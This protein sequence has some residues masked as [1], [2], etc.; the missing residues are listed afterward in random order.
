[1]L[2]LTVFTHHHDDETA[3]DEECSAC[4]FSEHHTAVVPAIADLVYLQPDISIQLFF[5]TVNLP[6]TLTNTTQ[7][8]APPVSSV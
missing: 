7:S 5:D 6:D 1:M 4:F 2:P 3:Q 8:R